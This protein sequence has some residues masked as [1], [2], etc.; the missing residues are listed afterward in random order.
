MRT[1]VEAANNAARL[2]RGCGLTSRGWRATRPALHPRHDPRRPQALVLDVLERDGHHLGRAV[3]LHLA[4][5]LQPEAGR[6]I[7]PLFAAASFLEHRARAKG[8][9]ERSG[10]PGAGMDGTGDELPERLQVLE[11]R[12]L[13]IVIV[14][15][16]EV[17]IS[18][19][20]QT[21]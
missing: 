7:I 3:D 15:G 2:T 9:V 21:Y 11:H 1:K 14:R 4:E 17:A 18:R 19:H 6:K 16:G 13:G 8:V 5:E 10:A 12:R 20:P